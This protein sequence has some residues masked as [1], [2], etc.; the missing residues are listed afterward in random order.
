MWPLLSF[1][2]PPSPSYPLSSS[3]SSEICIYT[4]IHTKLRE[5]EREYIQKEK[6][7]TE[8][9]NGILGIDFESIYMCINIKKEN[10]F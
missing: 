5:R 3:S 6:N 4:Y 9:L 8:K 7:M 1:L 10:G 2:L